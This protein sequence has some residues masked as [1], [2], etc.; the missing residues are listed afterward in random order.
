VSV[1]GGEE[2]GHRHEPGIGRPGSDWRMLTLAIPAR[3][4]TS[5]SG[6]KARVPDEPVR[7]AVPRRSTTETEYQ[8]E[9]GGPRFQTASPEHTW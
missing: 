2:P 9:P 8:G 3:I 4:N 6:G 5:T 7:D 1:Q